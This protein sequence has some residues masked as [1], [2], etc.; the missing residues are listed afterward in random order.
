[1]RL[2]P[3]RPIGRAKAAASI[4]AERQDLCAESTI[5]LEKR[6]RPPRYL[7]LVYVET[8]IARQL[9]EILHSQYRVIA[10]PRTCPAAPDRRG[11]RTALQRTAHLD[12]QD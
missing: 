10:G 3:R 11:V 12:N 6:V 4:N 1:V 7:L 9:K 8:C 2:R 5:D